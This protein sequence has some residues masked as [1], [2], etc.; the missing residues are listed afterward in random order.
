VSVAVILD[1]GPPLP[2]PFTVRWEGSFREHLGAT[3]DTLGQ[4]LAYG[5][6]AAYFLESPFHAWAD[7]VVW[8]RIQAGFCAGGALRG[9]DLFG[10]TGRDIP[11]RFGLQ[12]D[13]ITLCAAESF[14]AA[15]AADDFAGYFNQSLTEIAENPNRSI[16]S[17][18]AGEGESHAGRD[19]VAEDVEF[20]F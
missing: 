4:A 9:K 10:L 13:G 17:L 15:R 16:A 8:S 20:Q 1:G 12:D 14:M 3:A 11:L 2:I 19:D 5:E 7:G 18:L 6:Y